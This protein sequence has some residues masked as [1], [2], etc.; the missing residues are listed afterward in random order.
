MENRR[1]ADGAAIWE[2]LPDPGWDVEL[3]G[4]PN[5]PQTTNLGEPLIAGVRLIVAKEASLSFPG[6]TVVVEDG[7]LKVEA[8]AV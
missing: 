4:Y 2:R 3:V 7:R 8:N 5:Q 6:G 1:G